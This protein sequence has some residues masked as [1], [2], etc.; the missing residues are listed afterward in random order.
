[1]LG[2]NRES[3]QI[4]ASGA[5]E[6][7]RWRESFR[8]WKAS[9]KPNFLAT[10]LPLAHSGST[11]GLDPQTGGGAHFPPP[12]PD[13]DV[14]QDRYAALRLSWQT[15]SLQQVARPYRWLAYNRYVVR[16]L[17][18]G[19]KAQPGCRRVWP[20]PEGGPVPVGGRGCQLACHRLQGRAQPRTSQISS[21]AC[22][23]VRAEGPIDACA[24]CTGF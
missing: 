7:Q 4:S 11:Q 21:C 18:G 20:L 9:L 17:S 14:P 5:G 16:L 6:P 22:L 13:W 10:G 23:H 8:N 3:A 24:P 2:G 1:M 12:A 15:I 19:G